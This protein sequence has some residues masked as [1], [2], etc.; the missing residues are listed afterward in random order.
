MC[1]FKYCEGPHA[2]FLRDISPCPAACKSEAAVPAPSNKNHGFVDRDDMISS[3]EAAER[4]DTL[5][6]Q[7]DKIRVSS[8]LQ[9]VINLLNQRQSA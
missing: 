3:F 8:K 5:R 7:L 9:R 1:E 6:M 2:C 4:A